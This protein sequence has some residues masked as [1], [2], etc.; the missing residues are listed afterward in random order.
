MLLFVVT[1]LVFAGSALAGAR[2]YPTVV[3]GEAPA[4][5][6]VAERG[7]ATTLIATGIIEGAIYALGWSH[8]LDR[9]SMVGLALGLTVVIAAAA[10]ASS[11]DRKCLVLDARELVVA[12]IALGRALYRVKSVATLGYVW[13]WGLALW[14]MYVSWLAPS[15]AWDG[16]WYHEPMV[17][18]ALQNRGF[19]IIEVQPMLEMVNGYPRAAENLQLWAGAL[20]DR[21]LVDVVP[22]FAI[23]VAALGVF[24]LARRHGTSQ[25]ASVGFAVVAV[26]IPG[27]ALELR[28]T[29]VD[30]S[31]LTATVV[32][33]HFVSRFELRARD[34]WMAGLALGILGAVKANGLVFGGMLGLW[35]LVRVIASLKPGVMA[36][37]VGA[38]LLAFAY[39]IPTYA[40]NFLLHD[41][42]LW[43]ITYESGLLGVRLEGT[44]DAGH[45]QRDFEYVWQ[46]LTGPPH[47]GEN[48]HD[49]GRHAYGY[50]LPFIA[51]PLLIVSAPVM[52]WAWLAS[53]RDR[54]RRPRMTALAFCLFF[55][56]LVQVASPGHHWSRFSLAFPATA[57]VVIGWWLAQNARQRLEEGVLGAMLVLNA[58]TLLW[59]VPAWDVTVREALELSRMSLAE[60][61]LA[62]TSHCLLPSDTRRRRDLDLQAGDVAIFTDDIGFVGNLWNDDFSNRVLYVPYESRAQFLARLDEVHAEWAYVRS[63]STEAGVLRSATDR[64]QP[65]G[66]AAFDDEIF[67]RA[68][69]PPPTA[70][71]TAAPSDGNSVTP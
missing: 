20:Y 37:L 45:M 21:R 25:P 31:V 36:S 8:H 59:A 42:P 65:L 64:W 5:E 10:V 12:P 47:I 30:L 38:T 62:D 17:G 33:L 13:L 55:G 9:V 63:D 2:L 23:L 1:A 66:P 49:T 22:S 71:V 61:N 4:P 6:R 35:L 51:A 16:L 56:L 15:G 24:T 48:Y 67:V 41:N 46:E 39:A 52:V 32:A 3:A 34:V 60:R 14:T 57:L 50:A 29:Y 28:S 18:F 26:T 27:A 7:L 43:P 70:G 58:L 68:P 40:R 54:V 19:S 53:L 44:V 11:R 69:A